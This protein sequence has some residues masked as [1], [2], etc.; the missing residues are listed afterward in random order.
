[1]SLESQFDI[2]GRA[3]AMEVRSIAWPLTALV[4]LFPLTLQFV[5]LD[6]LD[7]E[8]RFAYWT[9]FW[10]LTTPHC[11]ALMIYFSRRFARGVPS[12][13]WFAAKAW[14]WTTLSSIPSVWLFMIFSG[15]SKPFDQAWPGAYLVIVG[16]TTLA[17]MPL[18]Y[19]A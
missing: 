18:W 14:L 13:G 11:H 9:R 16:G 2:A 1:R 19:F 6:A 12:P 8:N 4:L 15:T 5:L 10:L 7:L 3:Y 17:C